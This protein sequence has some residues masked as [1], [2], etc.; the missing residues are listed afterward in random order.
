MYLSEQRR[1]NTQ[2]AIQVLHAQ[3]AGEEVTEFQLAWAPKGGQI[4]S[5]SSDSTV[6][7]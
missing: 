5:G 4:A 2:A 3:L 1:L 7:V 6:Q